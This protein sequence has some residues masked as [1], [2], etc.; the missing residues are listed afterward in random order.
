ME[1]L[2]GKFFCRNGASFG[3]CMTALPKEPR[4]V[5]NLKLPH[6]QMHYRQRPF[7][8][9][10]TMKTTTKGVKNTLPGHEKLKIY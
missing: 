3:Q 1:R 6:R 7:L 5:M 9:N 2:Y 8:K 10:F 4:Y